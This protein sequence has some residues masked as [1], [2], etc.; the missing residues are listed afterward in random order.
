MG[1][2]KVQ[3]LKEK[4]RQAFERIFTEIIGKIANE[5]FFTTESI[6][7]NCKFKYFCKIEQKKHRIKNPSET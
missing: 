1:I 2:K 5:E 7:W 4:E 3:N 6:C